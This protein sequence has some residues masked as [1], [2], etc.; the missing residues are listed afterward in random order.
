MT[1]FTVSVLTGV[2]VLIMFVFFYSLSRTEKIDLEERYSEEDISRRLQRGARS[3]PVSKTLYG[4]L[5]S[6]VFGQR[7]TY[8]LQT[9][10]NL[11]NVDLDSLQR[12]I[13]LLGME[14]KTSAVEIVTLKYLGIAS[15][16]IVG[17]PAMISGQMFWMLLALVVFMSLF[18][19]PTSSINDAVKN[20]EDVCMTE[21]P[22]FIEQVYMCIES[23]AELRG[24]LILVANRSDGLLAGA[25]RKAFQDARISGDW[26]K[27]L[28]AMGA[29]M[30]IDALQE[31]ITHVTVAYQKGTPLADTLRKE[32]GHINSIRRARN[33]ERVNSLEQKLVIP[34]TFF[35]FLPMLVL[36]IFPAAMQAMSIL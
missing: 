31:F 32:V 21:L 25:F 2:L 16:F 23:G 35:I 11:F 36:S 8:R 12:K 27:E 34:I 1:I 7:M 14:D 4:K 22:G 33:K 19:L 13:E 28:L 30:K 20:R 17:I 3:Y 24:A 15:I 6:R 5:Y 10:N 29:G 18:L 9:G 26:I